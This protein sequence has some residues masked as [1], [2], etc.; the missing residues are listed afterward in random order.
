MSHVDIDALTTHAKQFSGLTPE[1]EALL[2][3]L[4][5]DLKP[6]LG[7]VTNA[8]YDALGE[9]DKTFPFLEGRPEVMKGMHR[10]WMEGLF[11]GPYD[12]EYAARMYKVGDLYVDANFPVEFMAGSM[13]LIGNALL[14]VAAKICGGD[15][16][17]YI[18]ANSAIN[19]VLGFSLIIMEESYQASSLA[20][21]LDKF[22]FITGMSR[23]LF[24]N[25]AEAYNNQANPGYQ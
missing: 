11:T 22:L 20:A 9:I 4:G 13:T 12:N 3:E 8:F 1:Y 7:G 10:A 16:Q 5:S 14:P 6:M 24:D 18:K 17:R 2:V 21:E 25:L 23:N 15:H 19:A